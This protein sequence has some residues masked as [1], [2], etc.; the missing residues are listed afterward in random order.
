MSDAPVNR[1]VTESRNRILV[2]DDQQEVAELVVQVL[3][4][5]GFDA[6]ATSDPLT[7][8]KRMAELDPILSSSIVTC[9]N[10]SGLSWQFSSRAIPKRAAFQSSS[11]PG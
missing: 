10:S 1:P 4:A 2:V 7:V 5:N 11:F 9:H 6:W 8:V 3:K